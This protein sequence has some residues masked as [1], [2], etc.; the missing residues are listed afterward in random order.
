MP[1]LFFA[2]DIHGSEI[3]W[4]KFL[5]AG[6]FYGA[7]ILVL[8]GDLSGKAIVPLVMEGSGKARGSLMGSAYLLEGEAA[9]QDFEKNV[10]SRGYYPVRLSQE[11]LAEFQARPELVDA[12][13]HRELMS[14][15]ERWLGLAEERLPDGISAWVCP[16]ND[17]PFEVDSLFGASSRVRNAEGLAVE[18]LPG[19]EMVS[20]GW[21]NPTPW[22][23]FREENEASL[24]IRLEAAIG[25]AGKAGRLI[26]NFHCPPFSSGLDDAPELGADFSLKNA[27]QSTV[28]VGSTAVRKALEEH[29]P[30]LGLHG[31]I[32][33]AKGVSRIGKCLAVNPGSLYEQ[34]VLQ[35][36]LFELDARKGLRSY[37]LT[38]G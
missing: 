27:G 6:K 34:G 12:R 22:E 7:D 37:V 18:I 2:T 38:T 30:I 26:C 10:A 25:K 29:K 17:D 20:S 15:L 24:G 5:G 36:A 3:C 28:P 33:E 1:K 11:E 14:T 21:A 23:T 9:M 4:K 19:L 13:F 35:G 8:G 32:H 16:G 31:H